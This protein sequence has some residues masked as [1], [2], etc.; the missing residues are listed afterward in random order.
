MIGSN[1]D[2]IQFNSNLIW[3]CLALKI[4]SI[5][6]IIGIY[7]IKCILYYPVNTILINIYSRLVWTI[8]IFWFFQKNFNSER[9]LNHTE[10]STMA[11]IHTRMIQ[12]KPKKKL[13]STI[14]SN[15]L[16]TRFSSKILFWFLFLCS[17]RLT[18]YQFDGIWMRIR[19]QIW[20]L[21]GWSSNC[22]SM[23][24]VVMRKFLWLLSLLLLLLF[25]PFLC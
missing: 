17:L 25:L 16:L 20:M 22:V 1:S 12:T 15:A 21:F 3:T 14:I 18:Y 2:M 10:M 13:Q 6:S 19:I 7:C 5:Y 4:G 9:K 11:N 8:D 23:V 24:I